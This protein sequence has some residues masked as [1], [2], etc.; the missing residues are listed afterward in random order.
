MFSV[1][2]WKSE[3]PGTD[4]QFLPADRGFFGRCIVF[5]NCLI[6]DLGTSEMQSLH[7]TCFLIKKISCAQVLLWGKICLRVGILQE[8][9]FPA[10]VSLFC[11]EVSCSKLAKYSTKQFFLEDSIKRNFCKS[12]TAQDFGKNTSVNFCKR[13]IIRSWKCNTQSNKNGNNQMLHFGW[14]RLGKCALASPKAPDPWA[15]V[16]KLSLLTLPSHDNKLCCSAEK[17]QFTAV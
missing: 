10:Q 4:Y 16:R 1:S 17:I 11:R 13:S 8:S 14:E 2:A 12:N 6:G 9:E 7:K 5:H 3:I 15:A